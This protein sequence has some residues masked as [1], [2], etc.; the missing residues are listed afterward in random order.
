MPT[1][2]QALAPPASPWRPLTSYHPPCPPS[3]HSSAPKRG[4]PQHHSHATGCDL[5]A[6]PAGQPER[7]HPGLQ[8]R[9]APAGERGAEGLGQDW[10]G[11]QAGEVPGPP[12][13]SQALTT[14]PAVHCHRG[15]L[16]PSHTN[17]VWQGHHD[18]GSLPCP[19]A[20]GPG[21]KKSSHASAVALLSSTRSCQAQPQT[22]D[23]PR[24][25]LVP[26]IATLKRRR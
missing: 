23:P 4:R 16:Q 13:P 20:A 24:G 1:Q 7:G 17:T 6:A 12:S 8:G 18:P 2:P 21:Y 10:A 19:G 26:L 14:G 3:A 15:Y 5:G 25:Y 11:W 9:G 22:W